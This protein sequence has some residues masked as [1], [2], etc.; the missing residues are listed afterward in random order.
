[1]LTI[2]LLETCDSLCWCEVVEI[3]DD[4]WMGVVLPFYSQRVDVISELVFY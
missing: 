1:V 2:V 3:W 4:V